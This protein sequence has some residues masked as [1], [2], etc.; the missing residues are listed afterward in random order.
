MP[1]M[2]QGLSALCWV[3]V[4]VCSTAASAADGAPS[5]EGTGAPAAAE[6]AGS[7]E[8]VTPEAAG[9]DGSEP[10]EVQVLGAAPIDNPRRDPSVAAFVLRG[11]ALDSPGASAAEVLSA[12]PGVQSTRSGGATDLATASVRGASSAE[13]P[14]YLGGV[15]LND[16][17]T[18]SVDL[19][20]LPLWMLHRVEIYRGHAPLGADR[21]G[22]AGAMYFEPRLPRGSHASAALAGG[23]FGEREGRAVLSVGSR[24]AGALLAVRHAASSGDYPYVDDGGTR[25]DETDDVVRRRA[26]A[27]ASE[28][29][30]WT[31]GRARR[32]PLRLTMV[33]NALRR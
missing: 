28:L 15:R 26:N 32:G 5:P 33:A 6:P 17:I 29:D 13:L 3:A 31:V 18:G 10:I 23:S 21:L 22:I 2:R 1:V 20:T 16:D 30:V 7:A 9:E 24:Q 25:F 11:H 27:Y 12:V 14:I 19:S 8:P 4:L